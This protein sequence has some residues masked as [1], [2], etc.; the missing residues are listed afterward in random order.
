[1][2][3]GEVVYGLGLTPGDG[4]CNQGKPIFIARVAK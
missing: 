4:S 1:M 2:L 3:F